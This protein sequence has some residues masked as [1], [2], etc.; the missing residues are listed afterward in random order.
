MAEEVVGILAQIAKMAYLHQ[1]YQAIIDEQHAIMRS[2]LVVKFFLKELSSRYD[3]TR[4]PTPA[5]IRDKLGPILEEQGL[6]MG[7]DSSLCRAMLE[8]GYLRSNRYDDYLA[9]TGKGELFLGIK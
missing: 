3:L 9:V 6:P 2:E 8:L 5:I 7:W 1:K 4:G